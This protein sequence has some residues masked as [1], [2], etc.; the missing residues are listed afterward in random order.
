[1]ITNITAKDKVESYVTGVLDGTI[2]VGKWVRLAIDRYVRDLERQDTEDFPYHIDEECAEKACRFF[3]KVLRHSK[4][5]WAGRPFDLEPWQCFI[6]WNIFGWKREDG[7]RRFRKA[8]ILVARKNGKTQLGAGIA[9]KAAVAD[10]EAV[11]EV[12]CAATKK[13]QAMVLFDEAER[14]VGKAPALAKH[15]QCRHHRI[16]FPSTGSK[17]VPLGSDKPFDGLN[18]SCILLDELHAWRDH[19]KPFFDT[20]VTASAA[21]RQPL[22]IIITTEGDTNSK[23]WMN[24]QNYCCGVLSESHHDE[25]IFA[26]LYSIDEKDDWSDPSVW[27]KANP[28]LGVSVKLDYLKEFCNSA[29]HNSEKR[30]QF[31]RYHCNRVVSA[32]EWGIDLGLWKSAAQPLSD[33]RDADCVTVGFDLGGWDDLA[34]LA[35]CARFEDGVEHD[36]H[37]HEKTSYRY[38]F[39]TQAYIYAQSKRDVSK[40]PWLDWCHIGLCKREEFVIGAIKRQILADHE[41]YGF[42]AVAYD[43]FNAQ[44]L[45]EELVAAGIKALSFRQNFLMYNEPLHNFLTLLERGKIR[46]NGNELLT[47]CAGNL[48][49][50]RDSADRWMPCKKSSKDKIDPLVSCLMA[51]RLAMLSPPKPKGNLFV[52]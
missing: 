12:Y 5:E 4:G 9:H 8:V 43:Q 24:E 39:M 2:V 50:K 20:M 27:M 25:T 23:L 10:Q 21:R 30:N 47:W 28:N 33:W 40:L 6:I 37:G 7:T 34:G 52:Y 26:I 14:M 22:T 13:E 19:H 18:P 38:E 31:L 29:K 41:S 11:S 17:I 35:Y 44:Q 48:A 46:H 42:E 1:M 32:T 49:I 45:G 3:P 16:L 36:E 51:F 15:A